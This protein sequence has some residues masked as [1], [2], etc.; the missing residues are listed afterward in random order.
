M[1]HGND[2]QARGIG[3]QSV[4]EY[5]DTTT[6]G[7][8]PVFQVFGALDEFERDL[9]RERTN[10]RPAA[11]A[12]GRKVLLDT[13]KQEIARAL[14]ANP[15]VNVRRD[16]QNAGCQTHDVLQNAKGEFMDLG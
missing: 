16:L 13:K 15:G 14:H 11:R 8:K 2:L 6:P 4:Q 12:R 7:G 9:S 10:A 5:I 1:A 3:F